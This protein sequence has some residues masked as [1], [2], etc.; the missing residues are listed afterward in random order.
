MDI[1]KSENLQ[2]VN[3]DYLGVWDE[4]GSGVSEDFR[5]LYIFY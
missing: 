4:N 1:K 2:I 3:N 5:F